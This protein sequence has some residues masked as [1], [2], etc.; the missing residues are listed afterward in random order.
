MQN[1]IISK[2]KKKN[3]AVVSLCVLALLAGSL[4]VIAN[5]I[6]EE[7]SLDGEVE[8]DSLSQEEE[9]KSLFDWDE[10]IYTTD[11]GLMILPD[12][13]IIEEVSQDLNEGLAAMSDDVIVVVSPYIAGNFRALADDE[14][15]MVVSPFTDDNLP[16]TSDDIVIDVRVLD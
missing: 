4:T 2:K 11:D 8:S 15:V 7:I 1:K 6:D 12:Y 3:A 14:V 10:G 9:H 13:S 5:D 16:A